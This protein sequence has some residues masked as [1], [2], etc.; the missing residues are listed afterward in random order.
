MSLCTYNNS[1]EFNLSSRMVLRI[2]FLINLREEFAFSTLLD[3]TVVG[4]SKF[5]IFVL[6]GNTKE[7]HLGSDSVDDMSFGFSV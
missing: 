7:Q 6:F 1:K 2:G 4:M 5:S 3:V